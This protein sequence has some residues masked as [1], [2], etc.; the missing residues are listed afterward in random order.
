[1]SDTASP[2]ITVPVAGF[3]QMYARAE[4]PWGFGTRWYE[5]RKRAVLLASLPQRHY[6]AAY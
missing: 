3:E 2:G 4:D 6:G 5:E 1:M